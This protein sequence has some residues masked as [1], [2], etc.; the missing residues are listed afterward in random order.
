MSRVKS[1]SKERFLDKT[2]FLTIHRGSKCRTKKCCFFQNSEIDDLRTGLMIMD[3]RFRTRK[4]KALTKGSRHVKEWLN[5]N[6][7]P[8]VTRKPG[9]HSLTDGFTCKLQATSCF[10]NFSFHHIVTRSI[11]GE[12][13]SPQ[14]GMIQVKEAKMDLGF[15]TKK[16]NTKEN[17]SCSKPGSNC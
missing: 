6:T 9:Y 12:Q 16:A 17:S 13:L 4:E 15:R 1:H 8:P 7:G 3:L 11:L 5:H 10:S 2:P 14:Q